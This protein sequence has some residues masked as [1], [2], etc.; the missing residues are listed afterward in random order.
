MTVAK[1]LSTPAAAREHARAQANGQKIL[2]QI[3]CADTEQET[4]EK[5]GSRYPIWRMIHPLRRFTPS[6]ATA[7]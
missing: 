2:A 5:T 4:P 1:D 6:V 7:R 3:V